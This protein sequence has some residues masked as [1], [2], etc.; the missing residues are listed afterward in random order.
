MPFRFLDVSALSFIFIVL[1]RISSALAQSTNRAVDIG[2]TLKVPIRRLGG[3]KREMSLLMA[4]RVV[5]KATHGLGS[6]AMSR[7]R[8]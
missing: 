6:W 1:W 8:F 7:V 5:R 2:D 3:R 4:K